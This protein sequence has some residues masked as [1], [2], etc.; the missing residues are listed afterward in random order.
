MPNSRLRGTHHTKVGFTLF[1]S[2]T[3]PGTAL[4][5]VLF[6]GGTPV[7]TLLRFVP[8][9][10]G[11]RRLPSPG[12]ALGTPRP[13]GLRGGCAPQAPE[14]SVSDKGP[15]PFCQAEAPVA[16]H[17][18]SGKASVQSYRDIK[19]AAAVIRPLPDQRC[20][21][22]THRPGRAGSALPSGPPCLITESLPG[23]EGP[24]DP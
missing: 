6:A 14:Q 11:R 18:D 8:V 4:T 5:E 23:S 15:N 17:R 3:W 24:G 9:P 2:I 7:G 12:G 13:A 10:C 16:G 19:R 21:R 20:P 22:R 1:R